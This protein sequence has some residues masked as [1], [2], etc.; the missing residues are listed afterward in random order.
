VPGK[1]P[2][3]CLD[4][5]KPEEG[6]RD[7]AHDADLQPIDDL[8]RQ[9]LG[10]HVAIVVLPLR[11]LERVHRRDG[12][13]DGDRQGR[14]LLQ[15][16]TAADADDGGTPAVRGADHAMAAQE[17]GAAAG[18]PDVERPRRDDQDDDEDVADDGRAADRVQLRGGRGV[19]RVA[20]IDHGGGDTHLRG[21]RIPRTRG[22]KDDIFGQGNGVGPVEA[23]HSCKSRWIKV[24]N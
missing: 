1:Q 20:H 11:N 16:R 8:V 7:D 3:E 6:A 4:L 17:V 22:L 18:T 21:R 15:P 9:R 24:S 13:G 2:D 14:D 19:E 12:Q 5:G 10:V 23:Q